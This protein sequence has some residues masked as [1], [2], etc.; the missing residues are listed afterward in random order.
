[1]GRLVVG[2]INAE[3]RAPS[4]TTDDSFA[5]CMTMSWELDI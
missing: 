5:G 3:I 1:M 4:G 2:Y